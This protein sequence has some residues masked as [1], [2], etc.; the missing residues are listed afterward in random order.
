MLGQYP[1]LLETTAAPQGIQVPFSDVQSRPKNFLAFFHSFSPSFTSAN[2]NPSTTSI[3]IQ[4]LT[5][6]DGDVN[7]NSLVN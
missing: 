7:V 2:S 3:I 4:Q 6:S 5:I 1:S